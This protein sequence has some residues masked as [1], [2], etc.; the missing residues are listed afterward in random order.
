[1]AY[2]VNE[3]NGQLFNELKTKCKGRP[4]DEIFEKR[5]SKMGASKIPQQLKK[6]DFFYDASK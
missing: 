2:E 5:R 3:F 6:E 1:M 4:E